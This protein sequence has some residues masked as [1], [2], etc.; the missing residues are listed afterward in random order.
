[1]AYFTQA[2]RILRGGGHL[3]IVEL[4]STFTPEGLARFIKGLSKFG[5]EL[6]G[7]V[8]DLWSQDGAKLKGM[9]FTLTGEMGQPEETDFERK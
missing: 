8:K 2:V 9:H 5:F 7:S 6:V 3:F 1:M 4:D